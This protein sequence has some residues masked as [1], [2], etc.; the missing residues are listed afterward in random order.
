MNNIPI[1]I[2]NQVAKDHGYKEWE[3]VVCEFMNR[4]IIAKSELTTMVLEAMH[5]LAEIVAIKQRKISSK[6]C[7]DY[8]EVYDSGDRGV[9]YVELSPLASDEYKPK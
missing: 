6:R 3:T 2:L 8:F 1:E 9:K 5:R 4:S 7:K